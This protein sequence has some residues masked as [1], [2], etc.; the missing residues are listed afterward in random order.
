MEIRE[1]KYVAD[2]FHDYFS[3]TGP[4]LSASIPPWNKDYEFYMFRD[5]S[6]SISVTP[7]CSNE[8][9]QVIKKLQNRSLGRDGISA[10]LM[11]QETH[12]IINESL[13]HNM[14]LSF[15]QG[16]FL[17]E[18]KMARVTPAYKGNDCKLMNK[19]R[20]VSILS[21]F[22]IIFECLIFS[23]LYSLINKHKLLYRYQFGFKSG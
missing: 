8:I 23:S 10:K 3:N 4:E 2:S 7:S 17:N 18:L 21:I 22:S 1:S 6:A 20:P 13:A 9:S 12:T 11:V 15:K 14:N 19:Y 5:N 16:V